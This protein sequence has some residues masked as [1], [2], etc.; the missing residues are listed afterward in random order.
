[1]QVRSSGDKLEGPITPT[2]NNIHKNNVF[3][4]SCHIGQSALSNSWSV[5]V[6]G[7]VVLE[8]EGPRLFSM[9]STVTSSV[10]V[11]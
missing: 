3:P 4:V 8:G 11:L 10:V 9:W 5:D 2:D 7:G 6:G 1:M